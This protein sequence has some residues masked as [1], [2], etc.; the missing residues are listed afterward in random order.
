MC[1]R[2]RCP[3]PGA[4]GAAWLLCIKPARPGG[5]TTAGP[6]P[7][8]RI[9]AAARQRRRGRRAVRQEPVGRVRPAPIPNDKRF[10][11]EMPQ[12]LLG[13]L[14]PRPRPARVSRP[15]RL[16][17]PRQKGVAEPQGSTRCSLKRHWQAKGWRLEH[18]EDRKGCVGAQWLTHFPSE[19]ASVHELAQGAWFHQ[20]ATWSGPKPKRSVVRER[21]HASPT[22]S[23]NRVSSARRSNRATLDQRALDL[24][25]LQPARRQTGLVVIKQ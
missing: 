10:N 8:C 21:S 17:D 4:P 12:Y 1:A 6:T 3:H 7:T 13:H 11:T 2:A 23:A 16:L 5:R 24:E 25:P 22:G 19:Q 15:S 20:N 14:G 9:R 18:V